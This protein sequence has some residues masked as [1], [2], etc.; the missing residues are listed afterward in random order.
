MEPVAPRLPYLL[1]CTLLG[2]ALGWLPILIHGPIPEKFDLL[3]I[4]GAIAVWGFY[5]ARCS[6]G[7]WIG[8][9][10]RP[11]RWWLRGPLVGFLV[12]LP[13]GIV[14][15]ATPGC[16]GRC[17]MWNLATGTGV[18]ALVAGLAFGLTGRQ[19]A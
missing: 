8:L 11:E 2:A 9:T 6:I 17:T 3:Y 15:L 19:R 1:V 16:Q 12:M 4:R 10:T 13:L 14:L 7:F 18:G 5:L